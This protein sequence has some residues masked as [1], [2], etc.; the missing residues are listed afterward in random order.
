M[1][2]VHVQKEHLLP[3]D[4][5][6]ASSPASKVFTTDFDPQT[7]SQFQ[8]CVNLGGDIHNLK[9]RSGMGR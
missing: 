9:P 8:E 6:Q 2:G 7:L 1:I 3:L 5:A 4:P